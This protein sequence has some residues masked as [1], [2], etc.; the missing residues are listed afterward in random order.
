MGSIKKER[1][2]SFDAIRGF[3]MFLIPFQHYLSA[4]EGFHYDGLEGYLY[5]V[6]DIFVMQMF[7]FLS[8]YFSKKPERGREIAVK[9]LLWPLLVVEAGFAMLVVLGFDAH[10]SLYRPPFTMWFLLTLFYFRMFHKNYIKIP[11]IFG[12]VFVLGMFIG[13]IPFI[14]RDFAISRSISWMPYFLLG[15]YCQPEHLKKIR[16]LKWWQTLGIL[17]GLL[18][19]VFLFMRYVPFDSY[20][21][22]TMADCNAVLGINW[23]QSALMHVILF[24]VSILFGIVLLNTFRNKKSIWTFFG[25]N[26][27]PIYIF[28][29]GMKYAIMHRGAGFGFFEVPAHDSIPYILY[30][31]LLAFVTSVVLASPVGATL[32]DIFFVK[33]YDLLFLFGRKVLVPIGAACEKVWLLLAPKTEK[34]DAERE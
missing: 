21:A 1:D 14:N 2:Y 17:V 9:S 10:V 27:M 19:A 22:V 33:S 25:Q 34:P 11:H 29:L 20:G 30:V 16:S 13:T 32:Y 5:F 24:P 12:I 8:G 3:C 18:I 26:T 6:I 4:R 31:L 23:W 7:F 15:Y 28:H